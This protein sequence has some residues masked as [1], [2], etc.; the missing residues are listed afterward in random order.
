METLHSTIS[1]ENFVVCM[2]DKLTKINQLLY[3]VQSVTKAI[4]RHTLIALV[5]YAV[6]VG[7]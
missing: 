1:V 4:W 7:F 3:T 5:A 6:V 2:I